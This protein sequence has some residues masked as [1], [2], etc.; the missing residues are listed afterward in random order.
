[1]KADPSPCTVPRAIASTG[2]AAEHTGLRA[3]LPYLLGSGLLGTIGVFV[4]AAHTQPLTATWFRCAFGLLGL[5]AWLAWRRQ[6]AALR[7]DLRVAPWVALAG[8]L[9]VASWALFFAAIERTSTAVAVVL[10][11]VQPFW[12]LL[13]SA[14]LLKERIGVRRLFGVTLAMAGLILATGLFDGPSNVALGLSSGYAIGVLGCLVGA[15]GMAGVTLIAKRLGAMP[16]GVLAWWQ[17]A[18]GTATSWIF[19]VLQGW[20]AAPVSWLWLSGLGIIHTGLAYSLIYAGM[21][22]I[23]TARVAALQFAYPA[24]AIVVDW[25]YFDQHLSM[26]QM[27]GVALMALAILS[28]EVDGRR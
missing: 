14:S 26:V 21:A 6:L 2:P 15:L 22:R 23:A 16:A 11:Q 19:P 10:F 13:L 3:V 4:H 24:V 28:S 5:T 25:L 20:P 12:V 1:M 17:C 7:L 8:L 9:L 18:V 27:A